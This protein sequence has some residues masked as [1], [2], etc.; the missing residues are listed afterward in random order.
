MP[1]KADADHMLIRVAGCENEREM[2]VLYRMIPLELLVTGIS[3]GNLRRRG[4]KD[5]AAS[6]WLTGCNAWRDVKVQIFDIE[7]VEM[8]YNDQMA[9]RPCREHGARCQRND[10][11]RGT[12]SGEEVKRC[13]IDGL[14]PLEIYGAM[15]ARDR[16]IIVV[17]QTQVP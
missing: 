14:V 3:L 1:A 9:L 4:A 11:S 6:D 13:V 12:I 7:T 15:G 5:G 8:V 17:V 16:S 2:H 10:G